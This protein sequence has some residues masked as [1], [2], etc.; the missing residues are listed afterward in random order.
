MRSNNI[1]GLIFTNTNEEKIL[2]LTSRRTMGSVPFGG[3]YRMIDFPLSN[4]TNAGIN[5][6]GIV[7]SKNFM[8]LMDH[9]GSGNAWDLSKRRSGLTVLPPNN[10]SVFSNLIET[11]FSLHGYIEH[12]DEEYV[13]ISHC[14]AVTN[15]DYHKMYSN[16]VKKGADI[17][18]AYKRMECPASKNF[19]TVLNIGN[20]GKVDEILIQ[21]NTKGEC[22]LFTGS[23][24]IKKDL[25]MTLVKNCISTNNLD[26]KR[27]ILQANVNSLRI[28][29]Y[30]NESYC[31]IIAS[32]NDYY[33]ANM[34]LFNSNVRE[35]LFNA[36]RPIYTKVRDDIPSKY[37]LGSNVKNSLVAQGCVIDGCV[38]NSIISKGVYIGK[39]AKVSNCII[40]QDSTVGENTRLN[41]LIID[42]DVNINNG[43]SLMG[44]ESYPIYITKQSVV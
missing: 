32:V 20:N 15:L 8:S 25:L 36:K 21:P 6:V 34:D 11:I 35:E 19:A 26:Y 9:V 44:F 10:G 37:G 39:G 3:K 5:N 33:N 28:F 2:E 14:D 31:K 42:K 18:I 38:E 1:L 12:G 23:M 7:T 27:Y 17:S 13:L 41:Y 30:E 4:M 43:R 40:M 29:G 24:L 22:N 16:H